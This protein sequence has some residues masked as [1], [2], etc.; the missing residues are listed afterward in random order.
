[1]VSDIKGGALAES[2]WDNILRRIFGPKRG[3]DRRL[4]KTA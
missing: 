3:R 4:E 1:M 2:I